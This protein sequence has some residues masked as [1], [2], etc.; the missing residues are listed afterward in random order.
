M[1]PLRLVNMYA[2]PIPSE[3][4]KPVRAALVP[5]P[6]R[7]QRL[8]LG[9]EIQ[10][11][12]CEAG[13]RSGA[14]FVVA[15]GTLYSISSSWAATSIGAIGGTGDAVFAGLR[16]N[17]YVARADKPWRW[18]GT[19]LTQVSDV[20]APNATSLLVLS[21][22]L[23]AAEDGADT[24]Y[25]SD[26]LD[27]TAWEALG[28]ATAEQRPDEIRRM[29][30]LSGQII[31][32]GASSIEIIRATTSTSLPFANITGQSLDET[33]GF[34]SKTSFAIRG[35][36]LFIIGGNL[37]PYVMNGFSLAPLPRNGEME[38]DLIALSAADR[39]LVTCMA[40]SYGSN[41]FFKVRIPSKA[42][43][44]LNTTT[45]FWH[46]EQSWEEDTYLPKFHATAYGYDVQADEG[47]TAIYTLDNTV[48]TDA[49]NTVERIAT[50][51]P[52]FAD[53][54]I[55]GSL[56]VDLQAFGRPV[57]G[58]GS[59]PTIMVEVSTDGR[60]IRDD[61]RSE[62]TLSLGADGRYQKPVMWG[63]GMVPP[64]E[65]TNISIR[66]TDPAGITIYG[67]W[68]NEGQRS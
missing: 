6:G 43:Y 42:A 55:I 13:V 46:R 18:N 33:E 26:V 31:A 40:Y 10:G 58:S 25:W 59:N 47:G 9:V 45:G 28:F 22:R 20:D 67:A 53:H 4:G 41:E 56:C 50:L 54:D 16:D 57:S 39:L 30:R 12:F 63:L 60:V 19:T 15:G 49:G 23:V 29:I 64:G 51:R 48:F 1:A 52:S 36:K 61:T 68:I 66:M 8:D 21:Q 65:A 34:L 44:V 5:T 17:L 7:V 3:T 27:G 62:I 2:V 14:L 35:D 38:D 24:Y 11:I 37:S 32:G